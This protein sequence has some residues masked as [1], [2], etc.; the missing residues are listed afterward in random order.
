MYTLHKAHLWFE[1]KPLVQGVG[2]NVAKA[3]AL[4]TQI[5]LVGELINQLNA[6]SGVCYVANKQGRQERGALLP[7]RRESIARLPFTY[8]GTLAE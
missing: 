2:V 1:V 8:Q 6:G 7:P 4:S 5:K 3:L